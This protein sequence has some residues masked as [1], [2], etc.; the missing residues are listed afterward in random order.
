[1]SK[2]NRVKRSDSQS[3]VFPFHMLQYWIKPFASGLPCRCGKEA[4]YSI[5]YFFSIELIRR[6]IVSGK[7][8]DEARDAAWDKSLA[9]Q[10]AGKYTVEHITYTCQKCA[11]ALLSTAVGDN[12]TKLS[13]LPML[14]SGRSSVLRRFLC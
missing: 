3:R 5:Q 8:Q 9:E 2:R 7:T 14:I 13:T 12:A 10:M 11:F 1:M 4:H 6:L